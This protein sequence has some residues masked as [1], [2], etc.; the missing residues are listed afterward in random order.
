MGQET[1]FQG[2]VSSIL[3]FIECM[4]TTKRSITHNFFVLYS[5]SVKTPGFWLQRQLAFRI[6]SV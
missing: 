4:R 6:Q 5:D 1:A 3:V 2:S